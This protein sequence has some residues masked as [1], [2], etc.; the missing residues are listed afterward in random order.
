MARS[1]SICAL[2]LGHF[3]LIVGANGAVAAESA[4]ADTLAKDPAQTD[5]LGAKDSPIVPPVKRVAPR[6]PEI[7]LKPATVL[8]P[9]KTA[10]TLKPN[11]KSAN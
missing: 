2:L 3:A 8:Q 11:K 4:E 7:K 9:G 10:P 5:T 6:T 1:R